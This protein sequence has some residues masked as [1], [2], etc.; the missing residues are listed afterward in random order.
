MSGSLH[1]G[2]LNVSPAHGDQTNAARQNNLPR[3]DRRPFDNSYAC[4]GITYVRCR[5]Y[6]VATGSQR[7]HPFLSSHSIQLEAEPCAVSVEYLQSSPY[8][9]FALRT[10]V[11]S[12]DPAA[13]AAR[14]QAEQYHM[15]LGFWLGV[16]G[17]PNSVSK[18]ANSQPPRPDEIGGSIRY[19]FLKL[20]RADN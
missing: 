2:P 11:D 4:S 5:R 13:V 6:W 18:P 3:P 19:I 14:D 9:L 10:M 16:S 15:M 20:L 12:Q 17:R 1:Y 8:D 7:T